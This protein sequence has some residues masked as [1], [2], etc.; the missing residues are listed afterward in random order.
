MRDRGEA[1]KYLGSEKSDPMTNRKTNLDPVEPEPSKPESANAASTMNRPSPEPPTHKPAA[2]LGREVQ[3][4]IGRQLRDMYGKF[5][6]EGVPTHI[7]DL[8][9]RLSERD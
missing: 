2:R 3:A 8:I 5:V 1:E 7:A 6:K 4:Q 9:D